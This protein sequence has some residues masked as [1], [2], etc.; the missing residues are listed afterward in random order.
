MPRFVVLANLR[1][2]GPVLYLFLADSDVLW[3]WPST[4]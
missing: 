3:A 4:A 1:R 2:I